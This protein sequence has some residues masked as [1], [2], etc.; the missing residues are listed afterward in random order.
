MA[1]AQHG[2]PVAVSTIEF[3]QVVAPTGASEWV[4]F[5]PKG[6]FFGATRPGIMF[7]TDSNKY[8]ITNNRESFSGFFNAVPT[9]QAYDTLKQATFA[10]MI[11]YGD[12]I[13]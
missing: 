11:E 1:E 8:Y 5:K 2:V 3:E 9:R 13:K 6:D 7:N 4:F 12:Q 10:F